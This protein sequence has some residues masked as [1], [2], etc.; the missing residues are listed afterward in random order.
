MWTAALWGL[1]QGLTEFLPISS[2]GHLVLIPALLEI[3]PPDLATTAVLHLGTL[4][5]V[6]WYFR[7]DL[8][9]L[10]RFRTDAAAAR[11]VRLLALATLPAIVAGLLLRSTLEDLNDRP[12]SVAV[13]L[14]VTGVVLGASEVFRRKLLERSAEDVDGSDAAIIGLAQAT[15]LVPGISRSGM[16]IVAGVGRS[17]RPEQAAR[18]AFLLG[19]PII[20]ISGAAQAV[21]LAGEGGLTGSVWLGVVVAAVAGYAAIAVLLRLLRRTGLAVFSA[22][23]LA[24]GAWSLLVL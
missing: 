1:V 4:V 12:R 14:L 20:A 16:T 13:A 9:W 19:I 21:E 8:A 17:L 11:M 24:F 2:S 10:A 6:L 23:C 18:F 3:E 15:A 7:T 22:Y 5:A